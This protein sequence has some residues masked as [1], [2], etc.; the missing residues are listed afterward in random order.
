MYYA[1]NYA[2]IIEEIRPFFSTPGVEPD[3]GTPCVVKKNPGKSSLKRKRMR[4]REC[5]PEYCGCRL[6][7]TQKSPLTGDSRGRVKCIACKNV[8]MNADCFRG[9][10]PRYCGNCFLKTS[11]LISGG[12]SSSSNKR[13]KVDSIRHE[14]RK[15]Q[16]PKESP[17]SG[18]SVVK[19]ANTRHS[20]TIRDFVPRESD[21]E[22]SDYDPTFD[23]Q[24]RDDDKGATKLVQDF[25]DVT[26][27]SS[28][29]RRNSLL[30]YFKKTTTSSSNNSNNTTV[31]DYSIGTS[32]AN[33]NSSA[34]SDVL[35][36]YSSSDDDD[37][38]DDNHHQDFL[39]EKAR[40]RKIKMIHIANRITGSRISSGK[41]KSDCSTMT[42]GD[43]IRAWG[44]ILKFATHKIIKKS[45]KNVDGTDGFASN[46]LW[47]DYCHNEMAI[48]KSTIKNHI[49]SEKHVRMKNARIE[50][51]AQISTLTNSYI[52]RQNAA[53]SSRQGQSGIT[54]A[55]DILAYRHLVLRSFLQGGVPLHHFQGLQPIK[56][57]LQSSA[58][59]AD[60]SYDSMLKLIP[61]VR[62]E[63]RQLI[64]EEIKGR[65]VA[66]IF[67][68]TTDAD[69]VFCVVLRFVD[70]NKWIAHR[71][72]ALRLFSR[73]FTGDDLAKTLGE[74][75]TAPH[76]AKTQLPSYLIEYDN[77]Q[78]AIMDGASVN[79]KAI[80]NIQVF[81]PFL[82]QV[83]CLSHTCNVYGSTFTNDDNIFS[84]LKNFIQ[85][86]SRLVKNSHACRRIFRD[87]SGHAV[88][89]LSYV[90]WFTFS[91]VCSQVL[92]NFEHVKAVV[93]DESMK[94]REECRVKLSE[95]IN[96]NDDKTKLKGEG[97]LLISLAVI[98]DVCDPIRKACYL[99]EGDGFVAPF[100]YDIYESMSSGIVNLDKEIF[101][102]IDGNINS[103]VTRSELYQKY[104]PETYKV[105][106]K[107]PANMK[108]NAK[109]YMEDVELAI[110]N[111]MQ[112]ITYTS[113]KKFMDQ[114]NVFKGAKFCNIAFI[115]TESMDPLQRELDE[116]P[117]FELLPHL[118]DAHKDGM[119]SEFK[120]YKQCVTKYIDKIPFGDKSMSTLNKFFMADN[121]LWIFWREHSI[122][123][124]F[125]YKTAEHFALIATSSASVERV[126]S[127]YD[128]KFSE[129]QQS[130][131]QDYKEGAVMVHANY[132]FRKSSSKID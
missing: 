47:C 53:S 100:A 112:K 4:R 32:S 3:P 94:D 108:E 125:W 20:G 65:P 119:R 91:D 132:N 41:K 34:Q 16:R 79:Q 2:Q 128:G 103:A 27:T 90:R 63:E 93:T 89:H 83:V 102:F 71:C 39:S 36:I 66:F 31:I 95:L 26:C 18:G 1:H 106:S 29:K 80:K 51:Q 122:E 130:A 107:L 5:A 68:G 116:C 46:L 64:S 129:K 33:K 84:L 28:V 21:D 115:Y 8:E 23:E 45:I 67:D 17:V 131:L 61:Y 86:W 92:D 14:P 126:F 54:V 44:S 72:V 56:S 97:L 24:H 57:L 42:S 105:M 58:E 9:S 59:S 113:T 96:N 15:V 70:K 13:Q 50:Q 6:C 123:L 117:C 10:E 62:D 38:Q 49:K 11:T 98:R 60:L 69:E 55:A 73:S 118:S 82:K 109:D 12:S 19:Y 22:E 48:K 43:A 120:K 111:L 114:L 78:F 87:K 77:L 88:Q 124:P 75:L 35:S 40:P 110:R 25:D 81:V 30:S 76:S 104:L 37:V 52:R 127:L 121:K 101:E 85:L 74:I 99:L 7:H